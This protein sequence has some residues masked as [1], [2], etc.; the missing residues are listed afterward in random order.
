MAPGEFSGIG[1]KS[2]DVL[3]VGANKPQ[4]SQH[5]SAAFYVVSTNEIQMK[6]RGQFSY[7][8]SDK[9]D[10]ITPVSF[11]AT[12]WARGPSDIVSKV[13]GKSM[14]LIRHPHVKRFSMDTVRYY[15]PEI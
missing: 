9:S 11:D 4:K 1:V 7:P 2:V 3:R 5:C 6:S 14:R 15:K 13:A 10:K 8:N 12:F